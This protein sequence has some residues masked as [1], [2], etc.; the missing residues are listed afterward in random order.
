ME[1]GGLLIPLLI[2]GVAGS[3]L[4]IVTDPSSQ[5]LL[6]SGALLKCRFA[7]GGPVD[8]RSLRVQWFLF[9]ETIAQYDQGRGQSQPGASMS[10]QELETGDASLSLSRVTVSD[11]GPYQCVVGYGTEQLQGETTLRVLAAPRLSIPR[12]AAG[13]DAASSFPCHVWGFYPGDVTVTWL[14]DGRVLTDVTPSAPQRNPDG[15]FN[16]TLTYTF[17]PTASDSGSLF[18]CRVSHTALAQPLREEFALD[19]TAALRISVPQRSG[20]IFTASSFPCHVWGFYPRDIAVTWL[21]DGRVRTESTYST[22]EGNPDGTFHLTLTYTFT[23]MAWDRGS[24]FSC[25]VTHSALAQPLQ[26]EFALTFSWLT[27]DIVVLVFGILLLVAF[28]LLFA[29]RVSQGKTYQTVM[30]FPS[31][32]IRTSDLLGYSNP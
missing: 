8:L 12:R 16:L 32:A 22:P 27:G 6:G 28:L 2:L 14:R 3:P 21:R 26:E 1:L 25:R 9:E 29:Y 7:V 10:E 15:T 5:A 13:R 23:P 20:T 18:S 4:R 24:L 11:E 31:V 30:T 17:T 19:V